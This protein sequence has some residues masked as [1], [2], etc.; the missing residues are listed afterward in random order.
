MKTCPV[1]QQTVGLDKRDCPHCGHRFIPALA[2][3]SIIVIALFAFLG[4][5]LL[6]T[7]R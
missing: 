4:A 5:L 1:C 3:V 7:I 2:W 6:Q